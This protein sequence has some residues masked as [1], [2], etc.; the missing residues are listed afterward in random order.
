MD[1]RF[2]TLLEAGDRG[3]ARLAFS[4]SLSLPCRQ[5]PPHR[6]PV[7]SFPRVSTLLVSLALLYGPQSYWIS[8][9]DDLT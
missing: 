2:L 4:A 9:S 3:V 8:H 5:L 1:I 6:V 7:W